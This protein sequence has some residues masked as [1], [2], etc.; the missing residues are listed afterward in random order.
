MH[1]KSLGGNNSTQNSSKSCS[2]YILK[3]RLHVLGNSIGYELT[4]LKLQI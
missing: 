2:P 4:K 3:M 1:S